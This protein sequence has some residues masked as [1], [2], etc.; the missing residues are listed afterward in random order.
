[1]KKLLPL[2]FCAVAFVGCRTHDVTPDESWSDYCRYYKPTGEVA[3]APTGAVD[4][5][6]V[7]S[8]QAEATVENLKSKG[9]VVL[10][11]FAI[12]DGTEI[13]Y[14]AVLALAKKL[15]AGAVV[16]STVTTSARRTALPNPDMGIVGVDTQYAV[17]MTAARPDQSFAEQTLNQ[18]AVYM[19]G[20]KK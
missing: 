14:P 16:W 2:M 18:H 6:M 3:V 5:R 17:Q 7:K 13:T 8:A 15:N 12:D 1:M 9:Y 19:L 20:K 11:N 10:G 4:V